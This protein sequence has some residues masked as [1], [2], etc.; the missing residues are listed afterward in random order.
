MWVPNRSIFALVP[1]LLV[2]LYFCS[3]YSTTVKINKRIAIIGGGPA[4]VLCLQ[5]LLQKRYENKGLN[6][7]VDLFEARDDPRK[8][9][10]HKSFAIGTNRRIWSAIDK[11]PG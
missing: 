7:S 11:Q 9:K 5:R 2:C 1:F 10:D 8:L 3:V 4:G 6:L